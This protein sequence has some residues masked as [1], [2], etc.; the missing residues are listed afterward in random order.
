MFMGVVI[1][2]LTAFAQIGE[3]QAE[4]GTGSDQTNWLG[5]PQV[6]I[7]LFS[8]GGRATYFDPK[9]GEAKWFGGAQLRIHPLRYLAIEGSADYRREDFGGGTKSHTYP[10]QGSLLIYPLGTTRL[11][12]F[13]LGGGGWYFTTVDG[14]GN[15]SD[16]QHRFGV[17][18]PTQAGH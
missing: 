3:A 11:A 7:G 9:E 2:T 4:H 15:F 8:V 17:R 14:P 12:P 10:V 6:D 18:I 5:I 1:L 16:T 13:I